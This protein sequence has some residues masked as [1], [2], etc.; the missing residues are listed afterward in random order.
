MAVLRC[1]EG[2]LPGR[3][4]GR[5]RLPDRAQWR[6]QIDRARLD[7]GRRYATAAAR[8]VLTSVDARGH[9]AGNIA[10]LGVSL[11]P[12]GRHVFGTLSVDR[13]PAHRHL[14]IRRDRGQP[15]PSD[16]DR[17]LANCS[18]AFESALAGPAGRL[19]G[20]EQQMLVIARALMT[21]PQSAADR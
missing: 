9:N 19:S 21:R 4:Q 17:A 11:V 8:S 20:G 13:E 12:E 10:R 18:H 2:S 7:R 5:D 14:S 6:G 15:S 16:P 3:R 1:T